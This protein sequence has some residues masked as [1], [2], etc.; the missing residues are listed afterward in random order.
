MITPEQIALAAERISSYIRHTPVLPLDLA[1]IQAQTEPLILKLES[2]Q[3][4]GSFK[5]RGAFNR[6]L[7]A[8]RVPEAGVIAASGGNH[9]AAVAY[10]AQR[11][12]YR[13]EIFVPT[14]ADP[15][16]I[17]RLRQYGAQVTMTGADFAEALLACQERVLET[18]ALLV[19]AYDQPEVIAGQGTIGR[20]LES[21]AQELDTVVVAVGGGGL[22]GGV[23]SWFEGRVR[24]IGVEPQGAPT[25]SQ[26][27]AAGG[28]VDVAVGGI[29]ADSLGAR[30]LG[31]EVF[32]IAKA[33]V[34]RVILVSDD[35]IREAQR[36]LWQQLRLV[37]EPGG[38][39]ALAAILAGHYHPQVGERVA[40]ILC[41]ANTDPAKV[42]AKE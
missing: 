32:P 9:G 12:G 26:A 22:I 24:V 11:L 16:K 35:Q 40:V 14:I 27:L 30:R 15:V 38:A 17:E 34:E 23:A 41:G 18:G 42:A 36:F 10:A 29:A 21:Q 19:H 28:P 39:A 8:E 33:F 2:L 6:I 7:S 20:E 5:A 31:A 1:Q 4:S 37:L 13:A 25:L 3:H